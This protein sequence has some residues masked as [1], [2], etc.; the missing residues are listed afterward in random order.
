LQVK[1]EKAIDRIWALAV[2]RGSLMRKFLVLGG[3]AMV[4]LIVGLVFLLRHADTMKPVNAQTEFA[5][6]LDLG[7]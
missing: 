7:R 3:L 5:V 1:L 6:E 4:L 2:D